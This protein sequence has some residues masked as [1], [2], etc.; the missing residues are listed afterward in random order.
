MHALFHPIFMSFCYFDL[1]TF[2]SFQRL[3]TCISRRGK[4]VCIEEVF[5]QNNIIPDSLN[6]DCKKQK[7]TLPRSLN[8]DSQNPKMT[9]RFEDWSWG[10]HYVCCPDVSGKVRLDIKKYSRILEPKFSDQVLK[11][12]T[13]RKY[14]LMYVFVHTFLLF[15]IFDPLS[16]PHSGK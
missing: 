8:A 16:C 5:S 6:A 3:Y 2:M 9:W 10:W 11:E 7:E 14:L 15:L 13:L 12:E 4:K 1:S